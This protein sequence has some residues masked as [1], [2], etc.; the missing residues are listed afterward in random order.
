MLTDRGQVNQT[1]TRRQKATASGEKAPKSNT[2]T[3]GNDS[4]ECVMCKI[5]CCDEEWT[6]GLNA[7]SAKDSVTKLAQMSQICVINVPGKDPDETLVK[8]NV[9]K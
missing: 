5:N 3:K 1:R 6:S 2:R 9:A 4:T 8:L 7:L